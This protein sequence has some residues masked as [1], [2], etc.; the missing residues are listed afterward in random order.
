MTAASLLLR[1]FHIFSYLFERMNNS[2]IGLAWI[3]IIFSNHPWWRERERKI[4]RI[5]KPIKKIVSSLT[6]LTNACIWL[7]SLV[8]HTMLDTLPT[9]RRKSLF[10]WI[11]YSLQKLYLS[12]YI[13]WNPVAASPAILEFRKRKPFFVSGVKCH[14][15]ASPG[16]GAVARGGKLHGWSCSVGVRNGCAKLHWQSA[17]LA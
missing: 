6:Y 2:G 10:M 8:E 12:L 3:I 14:F 4:S 5:Q 13:L 16:F 17:L 11:V 1:S 9:K 15:N 7:F